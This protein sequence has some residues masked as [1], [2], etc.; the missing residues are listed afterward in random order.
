MTFPAERWRAA[1]VCLYLSMFEDKTDGFKIALFKAI[2]LLSDKMT[3][4]FEYVEISETSECD[5]VSFR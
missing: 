5:R 4:K 1:S 3:Q 2:A